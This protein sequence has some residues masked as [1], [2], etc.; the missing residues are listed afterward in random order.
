MSKCKH[1]VVTFEGFIG[2]PGYGQAW[3]CVDCDEAL[4]SAGGAINAVPYSD[5]EKPPE[6]SPE[7]VR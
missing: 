5:L 1:T 4:W 3:R 6:L 2:A 7:D